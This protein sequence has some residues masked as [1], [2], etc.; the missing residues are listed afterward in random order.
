MLGTDKNYS[1]ITIGQN[2]VDKKKIAFK[3]RYIYLAF[4]RADKGQQIKKNIINCRLQSLPYVYRI[5][6]TNIIQI[7]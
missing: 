2:V 3:N 1:F 7:E 4:K 6:H 5:M